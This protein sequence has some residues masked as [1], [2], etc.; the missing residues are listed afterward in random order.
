MST[1]Y[2]SEISRREGN[3]FTVGDRI[4]CIHDGWATLVEG[5]IYV[6]TAVDKK[7]VS[8]REDGLGGAIFER[9]EL[10]SSP[11]AHGVGAYEEAIADQEVYARLEGK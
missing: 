5:Q 4:K 7:H 8:W 6:V 9:F 1:L 10:V 3:P 11:T 2:T